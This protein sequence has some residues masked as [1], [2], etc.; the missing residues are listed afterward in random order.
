MIIAIDGYEANEKNRV[1]IGR[2]AFEILMHL[3]ALI[4]NQDSVSIQVYL[5]EQPLPDMPS[6]NSNW[7]YV[8]A[9]PK[10]LWTFIGLP[11]ALST[12]ERPD[13]IFSPTHYAPRF[14]SIPKVI[15][16][17]DLS[18][19]AYPKMFRVKDLHKLVNWTKY[20]V[21][22]AAR[23]LTISKFSR[24]AIIK[25]YGIAPEKVVVTY[26]GLTMKKD[27]KTGHG[28][29]S[30]ILTVGTLQPRKNFVRLI[31]AFSQLPKE[32]DDLKLV[33]VGK[34]G[35]QYDEILAAP[36]KYNVRDRV[37]F[38]DFVPEDDL[39]GLYKNAALFVLPSLYEGF[40]LPV[41][42][43]MAAGTPVVVSAS[44]SLP[45]VAGDAGVY[46]DPTDVTSIAKGLGIALSEKGTSRQNRIRKGLLQAKKFT[47]EKAA[48]KTLEI[49]TAVG[50]KKL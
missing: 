29:S 16:I 45:E 48:A 5:P 42:E 33:I 22:R 12:R 18:Y 46:V 28:S 39:P 27:G 23:I 35:W 6:E 1:G 26:P 4:K 20:S 30:Y 25:E 24:N 3:H 50:S 19:L 10:R 32:Y 36:R 7:H 43:A 37:Q 34:K 8:I 40:G 9:G 2:Y 47:W 13:I 21:Q 49:I 14:T 38:L 31:E 11:F 17:M 44:S 41:L 15:S